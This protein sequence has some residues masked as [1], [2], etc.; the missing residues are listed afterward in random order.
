MINIPSY[1]LISILSGYLCYIFV[2]IVIKYCRQHD[3]YD[4]P[5][6]RK[7]HSDPTPRLGGVALF[8]A[9]FF[10]LIPGFLLFPDLWWSNLTTL[11]G[12]FCGG[13][14]IFTL[15]V[16][17]DIKGVKPLWKL[18]WQIVTCIILVAFDIRL[19]EINVPFYRIVDFGYWGIP[20]TVIWLVLIF[21]T[22][23]LI[24]GLDGLASGVSAI[25]GVSFLALSL[26]MGLPLPSFLAAGIIGI[27][28]AF[29]KFNYFPAKIF[30]GDSGSLFLGYIFGVI[31]IFWPKSFATVVMFVPIVALGVPLIEII[32]TF[33]RRSIA[34]QRFYVADRKHIFHFLLGLGIPPRV[35]VWIFYLASLQLAITTF[36]IAGGDRNILFVLQIL[37]IIFTAIIVSKNLRLVNRK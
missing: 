15:G 18:F 12:I 3:L 20:L 14:I 22:I 27:T 10:G 28:L 31:S 13:T 6:P 1:I 11:V 5:G 26:M 17:D 4:L 37:L 33:I 23:N 36:A 30:M 25:I 35:T 9:Y 34:G 29:L 19:E 32:T 16:V 8:A 24:D 2:P 21:N 7:I